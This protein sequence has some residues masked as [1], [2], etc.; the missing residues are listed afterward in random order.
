MTVSRASPNNFPEFARILHERMRALGLT[1]RALAHAFDV[2]EQ[3]VSEW[4]R[5]SYRPDGRRLA[6]LAAVLGVPPE[7]LRSDD[8]ST[9][10]T[11]SHHS[12]DFKAGQFAGQ[13]QAIR[14]MLAAALRETDG[15]LAGLASW[16]TTAPREVL[17][18]AIR[19][20][21]EALEGEQQEGR[22]GVR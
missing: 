13:A 10:L 21:Q 4:R 20:D 8:R 1:G 19:R 22:R 14:N 12:A 11:E 18:E 6:E 15:L 5:G 2:R 7:A 9:P 17:D 3:T 16:G